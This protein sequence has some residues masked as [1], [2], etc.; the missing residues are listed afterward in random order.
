[1]LI[2]PG[3]LA[4]HLQR[5]LAGGGDDQRQRVAGAVEGFGFAEQRGGEREAIGDGLAR[6]GLGGDEFVAVGQFGL[7][8]GGLDRRRV[9]IAALA[10]AR[11]REG[12]AKGNGMGVRPVCCQEC[13]GS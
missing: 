9:V 11:A 8:D 2:E 13:P 4:V 1:V 5:Q 3:E 7:E 6:S 10:R 12:C